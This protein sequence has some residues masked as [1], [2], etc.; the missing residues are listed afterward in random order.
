[1]SLQHCTI[2]QQQIEVTAKELKLGQ[3]EEQHE[4][5][6]VAAAAR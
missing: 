5:G 6:V 2:R 1:M 4:N 3:T